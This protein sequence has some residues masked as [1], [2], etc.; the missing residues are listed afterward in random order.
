MKIYKRLF[1]S[2][3][4][5]FASAISLFGQVSLG[6]AQI[7]PDSTLGQHPSVVSPVVVNG[8]PAS[9]TSNISGGVTNGSNLFHSFSEFNVSNNS[10]VYFMNPSGIGNIFAR[11]TGFNASHIDGILGVL[12]PANLFL[13]NPNG[14]IFGPNGSLDLK[15][16]FLATTAS[17]VI[18]AD[19]TTFSVDSSSDPPLLTSSVPIGLQFGSNSG[20]IINQS[21][22]SDGLGLIVPEN[23]TLALIGSGVTL[24]NGNITSFGN[25]EIGSVAPNSFVGLSLNNFG[26]NLNYD[27]VEAFRDIDFRNS[28]INLCFMLSCRNPNGSLNLT[29]RQINLSSSFIFA[30]NSS[31]QRGQ[32]VTLN[33]SDLV[34]LDDG[35]L[36]FVTT[37]G[38]GQA[39]DL[40]INTSDLAVLGGS[41]LASTTTRSGHAGDIVITAVNSVVVA[42]SIV[43]DDG[44]TLNSQ[45]N[46][47]AQGSGVGGNIIIRTSNL[48]LQGEGVGIFAD[49]PGT[50]EL[51]PLLLG[52]S[53]NISIEASESINLLDGA[54]IT[55]SSRTS[56][57]AG[58]IDITTPELTLNRASITVNSFGTG[59]AGDATIN[60]NRVLLDQGS[61]IS[62]TSQFGN[63]GNL[64]LNVQ[65]SLELRHQSQITTTAGV[66]GGF[67]DGGNIRIQSGLTTLLEDSEIVAQAF[68]GRGGNINITTNGLF[69][70]ADSVISASSQQGIDGVV[71]TNEPENSPSKGIFSQP[72][73][74]EDLT[75]K[76]NPLC[77][78]QAGK[79][80][81]RFVITGRGGVADTLD[82]PLITD[83]IQE[84]LGRGLVPSSGQSGF[85]PGTTTPNLSLNR[86]ESSPFS[87][88]Q[89]TQPPEAHSLPQPSS[90]PDQIVEAQGWMVN[91]SGDVILTA[92][93]QPLKP[94]NPWINPPGCRN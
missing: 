83:S 18:F 29:G 80:P 72:V 67:G 52:Q 57:S 13:I 33:A 65:D 47:S 2:Y 23:Q 64:N 7:V 77:R 87:P 89:T 69:L 84:D 58:S 61:Q 78:L 71:Q 28:L 40:I 39:G 50:P 8:Q 85:N 19:A 73:K 16:S 68:L 10:A 30:Q 54:I 6:Y 46:S 70:S 38:L 43:L 34:S 90:I 26:F 41:Q 66:P 74:V 27:R 17:Q 45:I 79:N 14:I 88:A 3:S 63:G 5:L 44:S 92:R 53:G 9:N 82:D 31:D 32:N 35:S 15:G 48:T 86:E 24:D 59:L 20:S 25:I 12:G 21:Q 62:A 91:S 1:K 4:V 81:S 51:D 56:G 42:G 76:I 22:A 75:Q 11:V 37:D 36:I 94:H 55:T 93:A 49:A 60:A